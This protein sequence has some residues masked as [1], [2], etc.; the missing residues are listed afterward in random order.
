VHIGECDPAKPCGLVLDLSREIAAAAAPGEVLASRTV[1]DLVP[2]SGMQFADRG[3]L[4]AIPPHRELS[5]LAV[6]AG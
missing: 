5:L 1:V 2:G 4:R 6:V 3:T